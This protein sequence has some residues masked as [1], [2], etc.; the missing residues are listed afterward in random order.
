MRQITI[1]EHYVL[2]HQYNAKSWYTHLPICCNGLING[3]QCQKRTARGP[4]ICRQQ[5]M[6]MCAE[7]VGVLTFRQ[8]CCTFGFSSCVLIDISAVG[9][10]GTEFTTF[11]ATLQQIVHTDKLH[12]WN[13]TIFPTAKVVWWQ[14][15]NTRRRTG[16][17]AH[18]NLV[19]PLDE[20][21]VRSCGLSR[22][23]HCECSSEPGT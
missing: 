2:A 12:V 23:G 4:S 6:P 15:G 5:K 7:C 18:Q 21:P 19:V 3:S 17:K 11:G 13:P 10:A 14:Q 9:K 8:W 22:S 20:C 16:T 1:C